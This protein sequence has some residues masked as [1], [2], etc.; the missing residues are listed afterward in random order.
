LAA[1]KE[2]CALNEANRETFRGV[3][4]TLED[5]LEHR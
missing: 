5:A 4:D 2:L 1:H 3:V